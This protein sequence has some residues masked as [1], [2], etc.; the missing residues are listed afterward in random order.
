MEDNY[1]NVLIVPNTHEKPED[2]VEDYLEM[3]INFKDEPEN[4]K[5]ILQDFFDDVNYWSVKQILI[6]QAKLT[7]QHLEDLEEVENEF[8]EDDLDRE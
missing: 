4:I 6:D 3:I 5:N 1:P 2:I 8:I 7:L